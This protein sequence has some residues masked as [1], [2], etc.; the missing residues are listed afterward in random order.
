MPPAAMTS[1]ITAGVFR[2]S[3]P[4]TGKCYCCSLKNNDALVVEIL[5]W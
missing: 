1:A 2:L 4:R 3:S 5:I